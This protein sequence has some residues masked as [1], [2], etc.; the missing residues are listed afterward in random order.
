MPE[1]ITI[2]GLFIDDRSHPK[3]Y[4]GPYLFNDPDGKEPAAATR[5][6][7]YALTE[8]VTIR[9]LT[10]TSGLKI[11]T[12]PDADFAARVKVIERE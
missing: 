6:F 11:R 2:D 10:T 9:R 5:P 12:S 7:T 4:A 1:E 8:Q 3:D